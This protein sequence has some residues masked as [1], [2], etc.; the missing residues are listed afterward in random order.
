MKRILPAVLSDT[1]EDYGKAIELFESFKGNDVIHIDIM[2]GE[3]VKTKSADLK[4]VL[5]LPTRLKRQVHLMVQEPQDL[6]SLCIDHAVEEVAIHYQ[7]Q[8]DSYDTI[9]NET[10]TKF[11]LAINPEVTPSDIE[12]ELMNF[13]G[14]L[15]MTV[16]PGLQGQGFLSDNLLKITELRQLGFEGTIIVDGSVNIDT[17][18]EVCNYDVRDYVVGSGIIKQNDPAEAYRK[19]SLKLEL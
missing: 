4:E 18:E 19:L 1:L 2:D 15:I 9:L 17:I 3:F 6:I 16:N 12:D 8:L 11:F 7:A 10:Q 5:K 13:D 14:V